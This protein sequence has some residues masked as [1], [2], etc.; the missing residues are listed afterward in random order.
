MNSVVR[1][2]H[3]NG[4]LTD[5]SHHTTDEIETTRLIVMTV[6]KLSEPGETCGPTRVVLIRKM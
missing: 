2:F 6:E 3:K 4:D 1:F 5:I